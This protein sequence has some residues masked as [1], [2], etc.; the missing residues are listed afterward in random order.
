MLWMTD[1]VTFRLLC[2]CLAIKTACGLFFSCG[3]CYQLAYGA[4]WTRNVNAT[5][6]QNWC[7]WWG[8]NFKSAKISDAEKRS[9]ATCLLFLNIWCCER[10][11]VQCACGPKLLII[12]L[13]NF[14]KFKCVWHERFGKSEYQYII[15]HNRPC[16]SRGCQ[17]Y[18][19]DEYLVYFV[20]I[21]FVVCRIS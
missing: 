9:D 17:C 2:V 7:W 13:I 15:S 12:L 5:L 8:N 10:E 14:P 11:R 20:Q 3:N 21:N 4:I 19:C 18:A 6:I 1:D 16:R